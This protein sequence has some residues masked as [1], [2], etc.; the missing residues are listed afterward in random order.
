MLVVDASVA[1]AA[2]HSPVGL[3]RF[4]TQRLVAPHLMLAEAASVLHEMVWRKEIDQERGRV[5]LG[6]LV[7][8]PIEL[9]APDELTSEA[10]QVADELGWA[11]VYD[12]HYV[13]LA[14]LLGC[15]LVTIDE[16]L[17]RGVAR[18]GIAVR[19]TDI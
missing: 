15:K 10:W 12:A 7:G 18:L 3:A 2:S 14:R 1:V 19:P 8:S 6:R 5:L 11:K 16:R 17:L 4:G 13:A 9:L